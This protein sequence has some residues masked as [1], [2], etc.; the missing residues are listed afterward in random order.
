M[1]AIEWML[2]GGYGSSCNGG[3]AFD[4]ADA[5][6]MDWSRLSTKEQ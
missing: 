2:G 6:Q 4:D 3:G 1:R 5:I